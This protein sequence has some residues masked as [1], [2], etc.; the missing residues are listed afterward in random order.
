VSLAPGDLTPAPRRC[1]IAVSPA[2]TQMGRVHE[3]VGPGRRRPTNKPACHDPATFPYAEKIALH[4]FFLFLGPP[5][6]SKAS[7]RVLGLAILAAACSSAAAFAPVSSS[8]VAVPQRRA[9]MARPHRRVSMMAANSAENSDWS[10]MMAPVEGDELIGFVA[11]NGE[12]SIRAVTAT[13][14][15]RGA[16]KMQKTSPVCSAA[17]GRT[18]ICALMMGQ[19][20]KDG[21]KS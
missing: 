19:G 1:V 16:C 15:V 2:R 7:M 6:H 21:Q 14:L 17:L 10:F 12:C 11:D 9:R 18:L 8:R 20:K 3:V 5:S 13:G 4:G